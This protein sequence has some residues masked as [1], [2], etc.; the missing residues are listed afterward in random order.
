MTSKIPDT[1]VTTVENLAAAN[2][3]HVE[4]PILEVKIIDHEALWIL[5]EANNDR[6]ITGSQERYSRRLRREMYLYYIYLFSN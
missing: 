1:A 3:E 4:P 6:Y 2:T 5:V